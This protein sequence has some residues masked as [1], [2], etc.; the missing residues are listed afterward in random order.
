MSNPPASIQPN[1][2]LQ[3]Y[4]ESLSVT[5]LQEYK[6]S[7]NGVFPIAWLDQINETLQSK[8]KNPNVKFEYQV[9]GD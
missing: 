7:L 8:M 6:R 4:I 9:V 1:R 2:T 3:T 5:S